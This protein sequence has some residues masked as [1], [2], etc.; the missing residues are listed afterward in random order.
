LK[1]L[2]DA[3]SQ[4]DGHDG[5]REL[6][7]GAILEEGRAV[8][9]VTDSGLEPWKVLSYRE[10]E[11]LELLAERLTDK[12]IAARLR[13]TPGAIKKRTHRIYRKLG[14]SDRREAVARALAQG[15]LRTGP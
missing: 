8:R 1:V 10:V 11:V 6:L 15:I 14:A 2:L 4:R 13:V 5:Y 9:R 12:E 3:L 7:R